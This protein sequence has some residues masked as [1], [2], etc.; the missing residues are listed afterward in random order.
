MMIVL[1]ISVLHA[2]ICP[3]KQA[4]VSASGP[5]INSEDLLRRRI[6]W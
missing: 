3:V 4:I 1:L 5:Y 2:C 6:R